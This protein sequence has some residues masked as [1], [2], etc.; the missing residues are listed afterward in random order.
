[1]AKPRAPSSP[2]AANA[3]TGVHYRIEI[4]D[5]HA[6]L[7][8]VTLTIAR[9]AALQQL[10]LPVWIPG[11]YLVREFSKNLQG[12]RARQ[13]ARALPAAQVRQR[14]KCSWDIRCNPDKPLQ[15]VY[16]VY[17]NDNSVRTACLDAGRGFFN[18]S[19]LCLRVEGQTDGP[20]GLEIAGAAA[21]AG[22]SV[23]TGL[24]P[25]K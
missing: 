11:S 4:A 2:Q 20:Q 5:A 15:V 3:A 13:S 14:D 1:M 10:S 21:T 22:W 7:F 12:L 17:A 25:L 18:N 9:P 24:S 23:A 19:S 6:H 8:R 16:E